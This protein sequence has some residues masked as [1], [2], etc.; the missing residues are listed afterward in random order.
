MS[1][2]LPA[3]V[4]NL[5]Q[6][7][8]GGK[9]HPSYGTDMRLMLRRL[10][11]RPGFTLLV[12]L[13]LGLAIG[14]ATAVFSVVDQTVLRPAPFAYADRLV[15]VLHRVKPSGGGGN[16]LTM[17]KIAGWQSQPAMFERFEAYG[18]VQLDLAGDEPRRI[19]GLQVS[20]GLFP[21]LDVHPRIGRGF[22]DGD[23][24]PGSDRV[25]IISEP[26]W[27]T[28][29]GSNADALGQHITLNDEPYTIV[30]VMPRRFRLLSD[31]E[32]V[33]LPVDVSANLTNTTLRGFYGLGR[34]APGVRMP[35]AQQLA[36]ALAERM[37]RETPI[38]RT[39]YL[40]LEQKQIARVDASTRTTLFVL[41]GSVGFVVL[42]TCANVANLFLSQAPLRQREMAIR[43][44]L[45]AG[46]GRIITSV[47]IES[48][49]LAV[50]GGALGV[51]LARWGVDAVIAAAPQRLAFMPTTAIEVDTRVVVFAALL[52]LATGLLFGLLPALRGSRPALESVLRGGALARSR[53][54]FG[55]IPATLIVVEVAFSLMLLIGAALMMRT[56]AR[57]ES[58]DPGF[59]PQGLVAM[60]LDLPNNRYPTTAARIAF[61]ETLMARLTATPGI[62]AAA[63]S[64]G[65]PPV[66]GGYTA[67]I[68][69][70]DEG[71]KTE[72]ELFVP[73]NTV[74]PSYFATLGIPFVAGR[75]FT[76]HSS[77]DDV[78]V[79][80]GLADRV[81]PGTEAVGKRFRFTR[82]RWLS[83]VGVV[84]NVESRASDNRTTLH[85]YYP[86][87][88]QP[89]APGLT[90]VTPTASGARSFDY[91]VL[92]VRA[93]DPAAAIPAIRRHVW[94][95]DP[96]QPIERI[97]LVED[98]Y[99]EAFGRQR[100]VFLLMA[101]FSVVALL[102]TAAGIFSVLSH[103]VSQRTREIGIRM[104]VGA[105][106]TTVM[107]MILSRGI[108]LTLAG[109]MVGIAGAAAL[110]RVLQSLLFEVGTTDPASFAG[111][112]VLMLVVALAACWLPARTAMRVEP[113]ITLRVE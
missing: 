59:D 83:I 54:S 64:G 15:D 95:I 28:R 106:P 16:T 26:L 105:N 27:H 56:L 39:W 21:M 107:N 23:G 113:A 89:A 82:D 4:G 58:I 8:A 42:I 81:W 69:E 103:A 85:F 66:Q 111:V 75:N 9:G 34:L 10:S 112:T 86:W 92:V 24:R 79:S 3:R 46:R 65:V 91:R 17:E 30:G 101:A 108:A 71:V 47:L 35:A 37:Q 11:T 76:A 52:T 77:P 18:P 88:T 33:W 12:V 7:F 32:A 41:L 2:T 31:E 93:Q 5:S 13:P 53:S 25:V 43:S 99:A 90:P 22:R 110:S 102:L 55:R 68:A 60:R 72:T 98:M 51:L 61:F 44:A 100:F 49:A 40:G 36:D 63:V 38:A 74:T 50:T 1:F 96:A 97:A 73:F 6:V 14:A 80:R 62:S 84:E 20:L 48:T 67:G 70:T 94:T 45:G 29:F 104:A 109:A 87:V 78:I 19:R 57:L